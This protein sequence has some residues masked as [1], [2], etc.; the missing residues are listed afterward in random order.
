LSFNADN[1]KTVQISAKTLAVIADPIFNLNDPRLSGTPPQ[2]TPDTLSSRT[3]TRAARNL[4]LGDSAKVLD[5]L[6]LTGTEAKKI[7]ALV[8]EAK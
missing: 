2:P 3:L 7:F 1:C 5:R 6:E 4:G 8:P